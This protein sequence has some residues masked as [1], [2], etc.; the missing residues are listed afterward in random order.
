VNKDESIDRCIVMVVQVWFQNRRAKWRKREK[1]LGGDCSPGAAC[2]TAFFLPPGMDPGDTG[3][4]P[5]VAASLL[6]SA[7]RYGLPSALD[8]M[9]A[10]ARL[11]AAAAGRPTAAQSC[12]PGPPGSLYASD[13]TAQTQS[14][15]AASCYDQM[16]NCR[17]R[18]LH[19]AELVSRTADDYL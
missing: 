10:A 18:S 14:I 15:V 1:I 8:T 7:A 5:H 2:T 19:P 9:L 6:T 4:P 17:L 16:T 12:F 3:L 11:H 13:V